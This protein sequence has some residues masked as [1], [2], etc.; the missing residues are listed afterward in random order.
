MPRLGLPRG[1]MLFTVYAPLQVRAQSAARE[2]FVALMLQVVHALDMQIPTVMGDFNGSA[3]PQDDFLSESGSRRPPCPLLQ[4]LLGP[5]SPW[6]HVHRAL[7]GEVPWTFQNVDSTG[8]L[9][10]SRIDLVLANHLAMALVQGAS[11]MQS[12][13]DGGHSPVLVQLRV[14]DPVVLE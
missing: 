9:S 13:R 14:G 2:Q 12:V 11:V 8:K 10:D 6:A 7:L 4:H 1:L 3:A 5:A